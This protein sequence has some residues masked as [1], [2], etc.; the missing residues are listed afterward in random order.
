VISGIILRFFLSGKLRLWGFE[1]DSE[2]GAGSPVRSQNFLGRIRAFRGPATDDHPASRLLKLARCLILLLA[3]T[4]LGL[5]AAV[6]Q[7]QPDVILLGLTMR[8]ED[9]FQLLRRTVGS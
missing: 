5:F 4:L 1:A 7:D 9:G 3:R 6:L 8:G 2:S